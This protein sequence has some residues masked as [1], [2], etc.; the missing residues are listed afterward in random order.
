MVENSDIEFDGSDTED[1]AAIDLADDLSDKAR[2]L[3]IR[4][5]IEE[6]LEEKRMKEELGIF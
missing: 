5:R 3:A 1:F 6:R 4:R 2:S